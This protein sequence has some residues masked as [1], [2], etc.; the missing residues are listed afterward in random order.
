M[1]TLI[2]HLL[3]M[4]TLTDQVL[5]MDLLNTAK[6]SIRNYA[7][8]ITEVGTPDIKAVLNQHLEDAIDAHEQIVDFLLDKG[9]YHPWDLKEQLELDIRNIQTAKSIPAP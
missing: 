1:N 9:W 4:H 3:G 8:A 5:A 6:S 2:E 7:M